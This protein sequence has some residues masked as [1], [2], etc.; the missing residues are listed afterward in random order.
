MKQDSPS[1]TSKRRS[2]SSS[3][4]FP[5]EVILAAAVVALLSLS[6]TT[7]FQP[8]ATIPMS[9][10]QRSGTSI[11][12]HYRYL[13]TS[14]SGTTLDNNN[15][16]EE[17]EEEDQP[18]LMQLAN[19]NLA[20]TEGTIVSSSAS[21]FLQMMKAQHNDLSA[22]DEY[23]EYVDKRYARMHPPSEQHH[24][25]V[26]SSS[27]AAVVAA[28]VHNMSTSTSTASTEEDD[29]DDKIPLKK[30][31]L[32][33]LAST[34]LRNRLLRQQQQQQHAKNSSTTMTLLVRY[35]ARTLFFKP[36]SYFV[37]GALLVVSSFVR[38]G[39]GYSA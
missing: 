32:S 19:G 39:N 23:L 6:T 3:A 15:T 12:L 10:K 2:S 9:T 20:M 16:T 37:C 7:A 22:M 26:S 33:R 34:Q 36:L 8:V 38:G 11:I 29:D 17:E 30:L 18:I 13:T 35:V 25:Q 4:P 28:A 21:S 31:G 14:P 1:R 5:R 27:S 24:H